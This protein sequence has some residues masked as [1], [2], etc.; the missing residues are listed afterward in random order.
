V[1]IR[2]YQPSN[3]SSIVNLESAIN[4][5]LDNINQVK[6]SSIKTSDDSSGAYESYIKETDIEP[7]T[8]MAEISDN[9]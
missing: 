4:F 2:N 1:Y 6:A 5:I 9:R 3:F 7:I 8:Q